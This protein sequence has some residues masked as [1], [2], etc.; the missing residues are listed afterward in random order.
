MQT[1]LRRTAH[2]SVAGTWSEYDVLARV[3]GRRGW[4]KIGEVAQ[5]TAHGWDSRDYSGAALS[6]G[7]R[8]RDT[9]RD[10]AYEVAQAFEE[11]AGRGELDPLTFA[12]TEP[13]SAPAAPRAT[14]SLEIPSPRLS[15]NARYALVAD[16]GMP[17]FAQVVA[18]GE[19]LQPLLDRV[20]E[21]GPF[22][23]EEETSAE[24]SWAPGR[25][26]RRYASPSR[27]PGGIRVP[28]EL[29]DEAAER[30]DRAV[31]TL[32]AMEQG[33]PSGLY[34]EIVDLLAS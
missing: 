9:R 28:V 15:V 1:R 14:A 26:I 19:E 17:L 32:S 34:F 27:W 18:S 10:A 31:G 23:R 29:T 8:A 4:F 16:P 7:Y 21:W 24:V 22:E 5:A 12:Y 20:A 25:V 3:E 11:A 33:R 13:A 2:D 30:I 6:Q